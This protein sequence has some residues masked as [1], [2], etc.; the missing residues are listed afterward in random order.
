MTVNQMRITKHPVLADKSDKKWVTIYFDGQPV[1]AAEG[2][3]V[4]AALMAAGIKAFRTT[5]RFH[6]PRGIF[7]AIGRCSDCMMIIDGKPN[8]R[9]CITKVRDGMQVRTQHGIQ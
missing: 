2:E 7:C 5:E 6:E 1:K 8:T 9:S 4:S 3:P